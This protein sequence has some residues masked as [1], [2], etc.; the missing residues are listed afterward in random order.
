MIASRN[1]R[2]NHITGLITYRDRVFQLTLPSAF[3]V[4][5][6]ISWTQ[7]QK[8]LLIDQAQEAER[9][10]DV[11]SASEDF[12]V[13]SAL[14]RWLD[15]RQHPVRALPLL[16]LRQTVSPHCVTRNSLCSYLE[17]LVSLNRK[18]LEGDLEF[19]L[20]IEETFAALYVLPH[21]RAQARHTGPEIVGEIVQPQDFE[22]LLQRSLSRPCQTLQ[23]LQAW[24]HST[25]L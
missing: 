13:A 25:L 14:E 15:D 22:A 23:S 4:F 1:S 6:A 2:Q 7:S 8:A 17:Y 10:G 20:S 5:D 19:V 18:D 11:E 9:I 16:A 21:L 12:E 24:L 3:L